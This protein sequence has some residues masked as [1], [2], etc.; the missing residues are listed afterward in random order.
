M[1]GAVW[2]E[3][4]MWWVL[5]DGLRAQG[6]GMAGGRPDGPG[7]YPK[8]PHN[9]M[10]N[11]QTASSTSFWDGQRQYQH[12]GVRTSQG[13]LLYNYNHNNNSKLTAVRS[14]RWGFSQWWIRLLLVWMSLTV[15]SCSAASTSPTEPP[16]RQ[17][18]GRLSYHV[19]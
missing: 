13:Y 1:F 10:A 18:K 2:E 5:S 17:E 11:T 14:R 3:A 12:V 4:T 7:P 19:D 15:Y 16:E 9:T 6:G 8:H